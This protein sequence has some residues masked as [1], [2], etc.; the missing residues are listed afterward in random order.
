M[1]PE[2]TRGNGWNQREPEELR[3]PEETRGNGWNQR[4][5]EGKAIA[6]ASAL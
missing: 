4:E 3:E 5:P 1:E 2:G 6:I